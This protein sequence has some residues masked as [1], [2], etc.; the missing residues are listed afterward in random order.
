MR[1]KDPWEQPSKDRRSEGPMVK[2]R[3]TWRDT[4]LTTAFTITWPFLVAGALLLVGIGIMLGKWV[5]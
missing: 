5:F 4:V 2:V 1:P 3:R